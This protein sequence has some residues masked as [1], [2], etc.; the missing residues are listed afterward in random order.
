MAEKNTARCAFSGKAFHRLATRDRRY[1]GMHANVNAIAA[2]G[3]VESVVIA[4]LDPAIHP[5]SQEDGCAG[6]A[7]A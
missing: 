4:G 6:Q 5:L 2:P 1:V 7:R 3:H